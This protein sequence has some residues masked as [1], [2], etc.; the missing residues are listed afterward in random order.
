MSGK[1][2]KKAQYEVYPRLI[3]KVLHR[4][5]K[6]DD[7]KKGDSDTDILLR[8]FYVDPYFVQSMDFF[9]MAEEHFWPRE[10]N[11]TIFPENTAVLENLFKAKFS[12]EKTG[13]FDLPFNSFILSLPMGYKVD[14]YPIPSCMVTWVNYQDSYDYTVLPFCDY[15]GIPRPSGMKH[16]VSDPDERCLVI[17]YKDHTHPD[18]YCR[19]MALESYLPRILKAQSTQ[20]FLEIMGTYKNSTLLGVIKPDD[21]DLNIQFRLFKLIAAIG[22]YNTA[23]EGKKL[24]DG[25]P[26]SLSAKVSGKASDV[27]YANSTL[28]NFTMLK[29]GG[30]GSKSSPE[31]HVR[32]WHFRELRDER[33]YRGEHKDKPIGSRIILIPATTVGGEVTP[34]TQ[35]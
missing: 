30:G 27:K 18:S 6:S 8:L 24:T 10:G 25:F 15:L 1:Q 16:Q 29:D 11:H 19:I 14:G 20:E 7:Y 4:V 9:I 32:G 3:D 22:V 2:V 26:Q 12:I 35:K 17:S 33:Y 21:L 13:A 34:H 31:F 23:T 5:K 28:S